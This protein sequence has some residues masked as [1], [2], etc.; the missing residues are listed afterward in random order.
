[1]PNCILKGIFLNSLTIQILH[2]KK[3]QHTIKNL[4][5]TNK[6]G[7]IVFVSPTFRG[8]V[9]DK[10]LADTLLITKK[11]TLLTDLGFYGWK[12]PETIVVMPHKK[13]KKKS[14]TK[15]QKV[16]NRLQSRERV[17]IFGTLTILVD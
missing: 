17:K 7:L 8:K 9:H 2:R 5:I 3:K 12:L 10:L 4:V 16:Q 13:P 11:C 1:M 15:L 6:D 14:L